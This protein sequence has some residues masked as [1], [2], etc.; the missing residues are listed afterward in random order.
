MNKGTN[1]LWMLIASSLSIGSALAAD[2]LPAKERDQQQAQTQNQTTVGSQLMTAEERKTHRAK[3][4][5]SASREDREKVR[6]EHHEVM[7]QRAKEQGTTIPEHP[8]AGGM[9]AGRR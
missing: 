4:R 9:G 1:L 2:Q 3:M 5:S 8:P 6:A 7:K